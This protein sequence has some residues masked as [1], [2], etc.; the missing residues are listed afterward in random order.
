[1]QMEARLRE[2]EWALKQEQAKS[3][4]AEELKADALRA[5]ASSRAT[6]SKDM[7]DAQV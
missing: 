7:E 3:A 5:L 6:A 4:A 2:V 1:M